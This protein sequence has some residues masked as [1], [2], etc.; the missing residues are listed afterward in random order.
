MSSPK[1]PLPK[2]RSRDVTDGAER[3]PARAMLRAAGLSEE[4]FGKPQIGIAS[5]WSQVTPCNAHIDELEQL[6]HQGHDIG[7]RD[8]LPRPDGQ[9]TVDIGLIL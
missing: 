5:T 6:G 7:L 2:P 8:R 9:G 3:A 1:R 4:D